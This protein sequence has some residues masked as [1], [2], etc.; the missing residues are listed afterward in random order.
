MASTAVLRVT[1]PFYGILSDW[2][3][4]RTG[5]EMEQTGDEVAHWEWEKMRSNLLQRTP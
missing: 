4:P 3:V 1:L 2:P 5:E